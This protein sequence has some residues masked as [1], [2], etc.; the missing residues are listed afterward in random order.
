MKIHNLEGY[1]YKQWERGLVTPINDQILKKWELHQ[2][3]YL[4]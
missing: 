4:C 1:S 3:N 2:L